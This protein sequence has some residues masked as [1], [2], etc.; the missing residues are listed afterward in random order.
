MATHAFAALVGAALLASLSMAW[1]LGANSNSPPFAPAIGANAI[2]TMRAAFLVG[3]LATA[4][5]VTQGGSISA[6]VG[7]RLIE[8]ATIT[9]LAA[10]AGLVTAAAY[11]GLGVYSGYPIPAAFAT[12]GAM[13]GVGIALGGDPAW[14]VYRRIGAFW[15]AVPV[16][17]GGIAYLT[18]TLLRRDDV[19]ETVGVPLLAA[20]VGGL[21]AHVRLGVVPAPP[22]RDQGT[23]AGLAARAVGGPDPLPGVDPAAVGV[24]LAFAAVAFVAVRRRTRR[25]VKGGI[26]SFLLVL[27]GV[28]AFSSGGTQVGLATGPLEHLFRVRLGLPGIALL[29]V[30]GT[31]IL[32]G[33][34]MGAPRLLQATSRE[35]AQLGVRRSIAALVPGFVIAQAAVALGVPVSFNNIVL[36]GVIGSGLAAGT[37][38]VSRR[39]IATTVVFWLLTLGSSVLVGYGLYRGLSGLL[40]IR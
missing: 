18:A 4:G 34:W 6:T 9:P 12:T 39:K 35:Y 14:A 40:G 8:G 36:S 11:M 3:V 16:V 33:A 25:S 24:T 30:G 5:A 20:F 1:A 17:S 28:V 32:A 7:S 19:P 27:G 22:G 31:G 10:T 2:S 38:G 26:R 23:V 21:L 13:I 37:A 15:L 29:A